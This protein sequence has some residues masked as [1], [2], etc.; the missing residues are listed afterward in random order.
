[1]KKFQLLLLVLLTTV[2]YSQTRS[3]QADRMNFVP[4]ELIVKLKDGVDAGITYK[5]TAK[6]VATTK[7]SKDVAS[8]L[9]IGDKVEN[10]EALFSQET[11]DKSVL[12]VQKQTA[13]RMTNK[14]TNGTA[15]T[16]EQ[17]PDYTT[18]LK[19]VFKLE[20]KEKTENVL[21]LIEELKA[22]AMVEY[23]EPNYIYSVNDFT[24]DSEIIYDKDLIKAQTNTAAPLTPNDPLFSEQT[25]ITQANIDDV[26]GEYTTGDGSQIVAIL[27]TGVDYNHPDLAANIW[28]NQAELNGVPGYDDDGNGYIDD[29]H[30]WDFINRDNAPLDDNMHG[31][32]VAG[33]VGAVGNNGIG[34]AGAAWNVKLMP[35]K[36]F[37][38]NGTGNTTTIAEGVTYATQ[39]GAM[40]QNMSFGSYAESSTLKSALETAYASSVLV[41][42]AGNDKICIGPGK[43][44]DGKPSAPLYPGA[45]TYVLGVEDS[46]GVYDNYD[47]DG[48]IFSGYPNFLNYEVMSN[49]TQIMSTV[50]NG[51][52]RKLTGTSMATPLVAGAVALHNQIK[53]QYSKEL[54]FG[55]LIN[56]LSNGIDLKAALNVVPTP[57]LK[58]LS[59]TIKDTINAQNGNGFWEPGEILEIFP[60]IK[61]YWGPSDDIRV[62]IEFWE[63][64]DNTKAEILTPEAAI[65]S[66]TAYA[67]LQ[68]LT[69]P[70]RIKLANN[71]A[72]NVNIQFKVSVWVGDNKEYLSSTKII[73][74][75]KKAILLYGVQSEDIT[76]YPEFEYLVTSNLIINNNA[77]LVINPG[78]KLTFSDDT[79]LTLLDN[80]QLLAN[81]TYEKP[82][83][84]INENIGWGGFNFISQS[85]SNINFA[86]IEGIVNFS[87]DCQCILNFPGIGIN[88]KNVVFQ[89][90]SAFYIINGSPYYGK[91]PDAYFDLITF[92]NNNILQ[93]GTTA[94]RFRS[95]YN[96]FRRINF[97]NNYGFSVN[98]GVFE[99]ND[100]DLDP[101][102]K[103]NI[104]NNPTTKGTFE[105]FTRGNWGTIKANFYIGTSNIKVMDTK[106]YDLT[107]GADFPVIIDRSTLRSIP[108]EENNGVVWKVL[109]NGKDAQDE[110]EQMDPVGL[111]EHEFQVYYSR[112]MDTLVKP[113]VSYGV[114]EPYN[115][116]IISENGTW[117]ADGKIYTVTHKIGIGAADGINRIRVQGAK[118]LDNFEIPVEDSRFNML[119][120]SAGSASAGFMATPGLGEI[121]LEWEAP[122]ETDLNDVLGYNMYRYT[123]NA[124]GT[125]TEPVKTNTSLITDVAYKDYN[126]V[127][128]KQYFYKYKILR[129]SFEETDYS[130]AVSAQLLTASL[131]DSNGD[132]AVNVLDVVNTVDYI[133]G[134]N[135]SPFIDYA[136]DLNADN[137]VNVL[138][139]VG[140]VNLILNPTTS[141]VRL[142]GEPVNYF[143][144]NATSKA[145]FYWDKNDLY[146]VNKE[147]IGGI[148]LAFDKGFNY[149]LNKELSFF[150]TLKYQQDNQEMLMLFA[151]NEGQLP[152]GTHKIL[153]RAEDSALLTIKKGV[154]GS[155]AGTPIEIA[156]ADIPLGLINAPEQTNEFKILSYS[157][158]PT[159]GA[160]DLYY[161]LPETVEQLHVALYDLS[162]KMVYHTN[163]LK[164][165]AGYALKELNFSHIN[166]GVYIMSLYADSP[167]AEKYIK[168]V[169]LIIK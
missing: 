37:Q 88:W 87:K 124:D 75:V 18:T 40:I 62:G 59:A 49:G 3:P 92:K 55:T 110:Y 15:K 36:V 117:S 106:I 118:D 53:P 113:Q 51:G 100:I 135:P 141:S 129:T 24:V 167:K 44:P 130:N 107:T 33:I 131:G 157:P 153:S 152:A 98:S 35:I 128:N 60:T 17:G 8:M 94:D 97:I 161:Y 79:K 136:T 114:R 163:D 127:R 109:V 143:S 133:L 99:F 86:Y 103:L 121:D 30:G 12:L 83:I 132:S 23:A 145:T 111:G 154:I 2:G 112:Q 34:I 108:Y 134:N 85:P 4:G 20:L 119:V 166:T 45:Y 151:M 31:T 29:V 6:G 25:N 155:K 21:G 42:A 159:D 14:S 7:V 65:G 26:W 139:I 146:L 58:V 71:V 39:N 123:A 81:G 162:G 74:N 70:L 95:S 105:L 46:A 27:D 76:L 16:V 22:N 68:S 10:Y 126:V 43:C 66:I 93:N 57:E 64:E 148:Q 147:A 101:E 122:A 54:L 165:T 11:V 72:N 164:N 50:P 78:V 82:I 149:K 73:V 115:Q 28:T 47:Q 104:F 120:Q 150:E 52:Y 89:N 80:A 140:I 137:N 84:F 67:N 90:N 38:S 13:K 48:P 96:Y 61:N 144:T 91:H 1:M 56:T 125:F 77:K 169:K 9:G 138:D 116:K 160:V 156:Y 69:S 5:S 168:N 41:G 102:L 19:N 158:N 32:H 63:F 142:G